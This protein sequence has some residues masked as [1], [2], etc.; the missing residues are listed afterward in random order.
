MAYSMYISHV[1]CLYKWRAKL[2][3]SM[4]ILACFKKP[5]GGLSL[6]FDKTA[7]GYKI[8]SRS[9]LSSIKTILLYDNGWFAGC[10]W[11]SSHYATHHFSQRILIYKVSELCTYFQSDW[12]IIVIFPQIAQFKFYIQRSSEHIFTVDVVYVFLVGFVFFF[13]S[14]KTT[15]SLPWVVCCPSLNLWNRIDWSSSLR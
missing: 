10:E 12:K 7:L 2:F 3:F 14:F 9:L 1:Y 8:V 15:H 4:I 13:I 5:E 6:L 11:W